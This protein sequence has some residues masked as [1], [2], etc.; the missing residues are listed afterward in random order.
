MH[1][2]LCDEHQAQLLKFES[3]LLGKRQQRAAFVGTDSGNGR[4]YHI[5]MQAQSIKKVKLVSI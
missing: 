4:L 2:S 3:Q 1:R 5:G